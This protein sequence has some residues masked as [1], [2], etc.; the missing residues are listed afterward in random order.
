MHNRRLYIVDLIEAD[1]TDNMFLAAA[2]E[3][4]ADYIVSL[5]NHLLRLGWYHGIDIVRP[6]LFLRRLREQRAASTTPDV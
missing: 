3:G 2:L 1:P 4:Q 6:A 5:D